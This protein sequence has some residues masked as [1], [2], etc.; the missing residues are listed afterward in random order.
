MRRRSETEE[1][2]GNEDPEFFRRDFVLFVIFCSSLFGVVVRAKV[3]EGEA[4]GRPTGSPRRI[5]PVA[6]RMPVMPRWKKHCPESVR[7]FV[8][9]MKNEINNPKYEHADNDTGKT[10]ESSWL[11]QGRAPK[12]RDSGLDCSK[13]DPGAAAEVS[14]VSCRLSDDGNRNQYFCCG[15]RE[16]ASVPR[17]RVR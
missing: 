7:S 3:R 11:L 10:R 1:N 4:P 9:L 14:S 8:V 13:R 5:R 17:C 12:R 16:S 6:D 15:G 2:E